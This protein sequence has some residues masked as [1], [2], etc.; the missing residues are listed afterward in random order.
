MSAPTSIFDFAA[1]ESLRREHR[2][3]PHVIRTMRNSAFKHF[4]TDR[5][6]NESMPFRS[7]ALRLHE[8]ALADRIDS[9]QDGATKLLFR[10]TT[11]MLIESVLLRIASGR[12]TL[13]VSS[14]VGCAAACVFCATGKMGVAHDLSP[15]EIVDQVFQVGQLLGQEASRLRNVVFMGMGEPLH[16]EAN[17]IEAIRLLTSTE[18]FNFSPHRILVSTVGITDAMRRLVAACPDINVAV[19]LHSVNQS[20]RERLIPIAKKYDLS[21]LQSAIR[22][23]NQRQ[24]MIE[25]LMLRGINDT[26]QDA[27]ELI[28]WLQ[29]L[30]V[31]VNLIPY[32]PIEGE[33]TLECSDV[34]VMRRFAEKLKQAGVKTT[35]RYSL[36]ND[37]A[38]ACGQL[39]QSKNREIAKALAGEAAQQ[40]ATTSKSA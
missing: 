6:I 26:E 16:N 3:D 5:A 36:G 29:G 39:V 40:K 38:A 17:V 22:D 1:V 7:E 30:D 35:T 2:V 24:V 25:Y 37:I 11:G 20:V 27:I 10:T 28:N 8:L 32:N 9:Q 31:H 18:Y 33:P 23:I 15:F 19:S 12:N 14:Q 13:C 4:A 21:Q 34:E